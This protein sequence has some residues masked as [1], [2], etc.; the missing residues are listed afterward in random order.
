MKIERSELVLQVKAFSLAANGLIIGAPG[1][2]KSYVLRQARD[3]F[4]A[5][6]RPATIVPVDQLG[7]GSD[8][9]FRA[10]FPGGGDWLS[11]LNA[12]ARASPLQP[13]VLIFD[14]FDAARSEE[15]R[16]RLLAQIGKAI[17]ELSDAWR[18]LVSVRSWDAR[19][20]GQLL[21]LFPADS[22]VTDGIPC[23]HF[24][25]PPLERNELQ[26]A[27]D[28]LPNLERLYDDGSDDFRGLL[29]I[30]FHLWLIEKILGGGTDLALSQITSEVQLL[31]RYWQKRVVQ[32]PTGSTREFLLSTITQTMVEEHSLAVRKDKVYNPGAKAEWDELL[33]EEVIAEPQVSKQRVMYSHNILFDFA[34]A[35]LL[36]EDDPQDFAQFV[37]DEPARPLF[38]RPS[39]VYHFTRQ[40]HGDRKVFWD[41]FRAAALQNQVHL[42]QIVRLVLPAV[43]VSE[44]RQA[45]DLEPLITDLRNSDETARNGFAFMLQALR[46]LDTA[47]SRLWSE[48][49]RS[50]SE[51]LYREFSWDLGVVADRLYDKAATSDPSLRENCG[52]IARN[53]LG[54]VW[55]QREKQSEPWLDRLA[56]IVAVPLVAKTYSTDLEKSRT[57]L[58]SVLSLTTQSN[59]PIDCVYRLTDEV[60]RIIPHDPEFVAQV[61]EVVFEHEEMSE[62]KTN[63]GGP[64]LTL[65]SNR[66]QDYD[67]CQYQLIQVFPRFLATAPVVATRAAIR[68]L[69]SWALRRHVLPHIKEGHTLESL[70]QTF[71]FRGKKA[72]YVPDMSA[73]WDESHYPDQ[74]LQ[75]AANLFHHID[76]IADK[77]DVTTLESLLDVMTDEIRAAFLWQRLLF[78]GAKRPAVFA[79]LLW[80]LCL[81]PPMSLEN[82]TLVAL[83][84][85]LESAGPFFS[86]AQLAEIEKCVLAIPQHR[87]KEDKIEFYERRRDRLLGRLPRERLVTKE[88]KE[89]RERMEAMNA[90]PE[91]QP[92]YQFSSEW[93]DFTEDELLREQGAKPDAAENKALRA[94]YEPLRAFSTKWTNKVAPPEE[95]KLLLP[96]ANKLFAALHD[97]CAADEPVIAAAWQRVAEYAHALGRR[98]TG[99]DTDEYRFVRKVLLESGNQATTELE[100][101]TD[102]NWETAAWS[103]TPIHEAAQSLPWLTHFG[104]DP[105]I[106]QTIK[107]LASSKIPSV[108]FLLAS[109]LWRLN[110]NAAQLGWELLSNFAAREPNAVVLDGVTASTWNLTSRDKSQSLA[111]VQTLFG[112]INEFSLKA[113]FIDDVIAML[114]DFAMWDNDS[115]AISIVN[116]WRA[117]PISSAPF[118][119]MA[120]RRLI[121]Y[122]TPYQDRRTFESARGTLIDIIGSIE[123]ASAALKSL[124][125]EEWTEANR[126]VLHQ[127]YDVIDQAIL[128]IYFAADVDPNLRARKEHPLN[129]D[130]RQRFFYDVLVILERIVAFALDEKA[131]ILFA[132]TAHHFIQLINGVIKYDPR[133]ALR[134]ASEVVRASKPFNYNLDSLAMKEVVRLVESVLADY[135]SEIQDEQSIRFL[136]NLLDAFVEAGW[137]DALQLVWRLD[138]IY[139]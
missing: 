139:R 80:E 64:V 75:I 95:L 60:D 20:S 100:G 114:I 46:V 9:D 91:N 36:L 42:R 74:P 107:K 96:Q 33:S 1:V 28:Q 131:G 3:A 109:E 99:A 89:L 25:I 53:L 77:A 81:A 134:L 39:L 35:A 130:Q 67:G 116:S 5:D 50:A 117:A 79:N 32:E 12:I 18:V 68:A 44:A 115:W 101:E 69:N 127:L 11:R 26:Q 83:G 14:G 76:E 103:P 78:A 106:L 21:D 24:K 84:A 137:P 125:P 82:D 121:S 71:D 62:E 129:D 27:F 58:R 126:T 31:D 34:V 61:Y 29:T 30:P 2:G 108:R 120:G 22:A 128:R 138:E 56:A 6:R 23:R 59:F 85:F 49:L 90:V 72:R 98:I 112:R 97:D 45:A 41:N 57:L 136:L 51:H 19:K 111:I 10:F 73:I 132:P 104:A 48:I 86:D 52:V 7:V 63:M 92:L 102:L 124:P 119:G 113:G 66:R 122:I 110:E 8:E 55:Q 87:E 94:L 105:E 118:V 65:I 4:M 70:T 37:A 135:R 133:A 13:G 17:A 15:R 54:W 88:G 38:L 47:H 43:I 93:S 16:S 40:W 123:S